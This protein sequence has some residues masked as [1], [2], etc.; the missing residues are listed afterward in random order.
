MD[1][2]DEECQVKHRRKPG[3]G[4]HMMVEMADSTAAGAGLAAGALWYTDSADA[5]WKPLQDY[6]QTEKRHQILS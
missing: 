5:D 6:V 2:D 1:V 3:A 4:V